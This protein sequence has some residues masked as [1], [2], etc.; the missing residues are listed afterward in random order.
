MDKLPVPLRGNVPVPTVTDLRRQAASTARCLG[1]A[2]GSAS[3]AATEK[4]ITNDSGEAADPPAAMPAQPQQQMVAIM[5][6]PECAS[7]NN[8]AP[9]RPYMFHIPVKRPGQEA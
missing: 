9:T 5:N 1:Y 6:A 2:I 4:A 3:S 8:A 7:D